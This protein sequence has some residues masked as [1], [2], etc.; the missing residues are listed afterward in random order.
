MVKASLASGCATG[1]KLRQAND[2]AEGGAAEIA[3]SEALR[4]DHIVRTGIDLALV[5]EVTRKKFSASDGE[6]G[7]IDDMERVVALIERAGP[8]SARASHSTPSSGQL[9]SMVAACTPGRLRT[10]SSNWT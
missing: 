2:T 1:P 7:G 6:V 9:P 8:R 5:D 10:R 4:Y 3:A